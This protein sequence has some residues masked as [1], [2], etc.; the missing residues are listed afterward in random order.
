MFCKNCGS[1]VN[2]G[3]AFCNECGAKI[4]N[5]AVQQPAQPI[6]TPP[7][8]AA[9]QQ[10]VQAPPPAAAFQQP[11]QAPPPTAAFQQPV[12]T[13]PPTATPYGAPPILPSRK[14]SHTGLWIFL[15]VLLIVVA[16]LIFIFA[17]I[18]WFGPKDL[19]VRY[20]QKDYNNVIQKLGMH[21]EADLGNGITYDNSA[22]LAGDDEATGYLT[23]NIP[24]SGNSSI[25]ISSKSNS[26]AAKSSA[27]KSSAGKS[28]VSASS[29]LMSS[30]NISSTVK[31]SMGSSS[32]IL[33]SMDASSAINSILGSSSTDSSG[34]IVSNSDEPAAIEIV[35]LNFE[36]FNWEFSKYEHKSITI[37]YIEATA[38]FNEIAPF[39]WWFKNTQVKI[40]P[41]GKI[42]SSS[43][44]N[45]KKLKTNLYKDVADKIPFPLPDQV[46]LYTEGG[47]AVKN[48]RIS[49][50]PDAIDAGVIPVK[51]ILST[52]ENLNIFSFY[53]E[54]FYT[55]IPELSIDNAGVKD[56]QFVFEGTIPTEIKVTPKEQ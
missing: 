23:A 41:D 33:S 47:F 37:S 19:G 5:T 51:S 53:L 36:D 14:K 29:A 49:M 50:E 55:T 42:I 35:D 34:M 46:N 45:I 2:E 30:I 16:A 48:N 26:S 7:P 52:G 38:F 20:T 22:I 10:P 32:A 43:S 1:E 13:P 25:V 17:K 6:Q 31:S 15:S 44:V 21:I 56:G 3:N 8:T 11:V 12:Q 39:F 24:N 40:Q 54:R 28:S 18:A 4:E 9:F 27:A